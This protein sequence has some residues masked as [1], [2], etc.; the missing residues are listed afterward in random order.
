MSKISSLGELYQKTGSI[1]NEIEAI[2][3]MKS[4]IIL[5]KKAFLLSE[6]KIPFFYRKRN[7]LFSFLPAEKEKRKNKD[8]KSPVSRAKI[9]LAGILGF[10]PRHHGFRDRCLTA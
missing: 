3:P 1:S 4:T 2:F 5:P 7:T 10:E 9:S 6:D 8:K